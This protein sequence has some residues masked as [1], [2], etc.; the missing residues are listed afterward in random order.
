MREREETDRQASPVAAQPAARK[1][2]QKPA[3]RFE[4]IFETRALVC[5]KIQTTQGPCAHNRRTS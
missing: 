5:G 4:R 3:M 1:P 2:Y